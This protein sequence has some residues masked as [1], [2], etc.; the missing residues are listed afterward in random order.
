MCNIIKLAL[1]G[2]FSIPTPAAAV[3][4]SPEALHMD[5]QKGSVSVVLTKSHQLLEKRHP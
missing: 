1:A 3:E 2:L 5:Y 4:S